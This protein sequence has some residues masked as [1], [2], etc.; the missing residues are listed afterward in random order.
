MNQ[1]TKGKYIGLIGAIAAHAVV[2][3]FLVLTFFPLPEPEEESGLPVMVGELTDAWGNSLV[4]VETMPQAAVET[5]PLEADE[6]LITQELEETV[7]IEQ[8]SD[9]REDETDPVKSDEE[10]AAEARRLAEEQA[11]RERKAAEEAVRQRVAGAFG[12]GSQ[13]GNTE[14]SQQSGTQ[15]SPTG[16]A[17]QGASAG[18]GGYGS[19]ELGGRSLGEGGLPR[20]IYNVQD[21]GKVVVTITVN[22][23]GRV[24]SAAINRQTNTVNQALRK[25]ALDAA[26]KARFNAIEGLDNQIGTI[27]YE[28]KLK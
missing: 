7:A 20:P 24:V 27:T 9:V 28:F 1:K 17:P 14:S 18:L 4:E 25:A 8:S 11:E 26:K 3:I 13:L 21:E 15:G 10:K 5:E 19:F 12:K 23:A 16:N 6:P 22:P 2:L